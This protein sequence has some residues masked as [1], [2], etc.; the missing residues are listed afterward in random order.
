MTNNQWDNLVKRIANTD[1]AKR[2][3]WAKRQPPLLMALNERDAEDV[4]NPETTNRMPQ[5]AS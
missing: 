4:P 5:N 1:P 3:E 2:E